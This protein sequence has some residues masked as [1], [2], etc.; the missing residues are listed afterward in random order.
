MNLSTKQKQTHR[1]RE[2]TC[3]CQGGRGGSGTDWEFGVS[4]RKLLHLEWIGVP[5]MAS[6]QHQDRGSIPNPVQW[7]KG[8]D[9]A[10]AAARSQLQLRSDPWPKKSK[11]H[12]AAKKERKK[13]KRKREK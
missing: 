1:Y 11:C 4:R 3:G 9:I 6:L 12:R 5:V 7:V 2:K 8:S 10:A 13:G